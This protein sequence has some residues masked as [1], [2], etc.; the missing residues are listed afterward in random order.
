MT[1]PL[2]ET[3][4]LVDESPVK[5]MCCSGLAVRC[6]L[7]LVSSNHHERIQVYRQGS[8]GTAHSLGIKD[9]SAIVGS[10]H[11]EYHEITVQPGAHLGPWGISTHT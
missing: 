7:A 5:S 11:V 2:V 10:R 6:K 4:I 1:T 9:L 3:S 8:R